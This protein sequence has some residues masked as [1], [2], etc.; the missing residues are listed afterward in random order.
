MSNDTVH[1]CCLCN[2]DFRPEALGKD[3]KC[4]TCHAQFPNVKTR[5]EMMLIN[6]PEINLGKKVTEETV[7]QIIKEELN[8]FKTV[9]MG[10]IKMAHARAAKG[11]KKDE[12]NNGDK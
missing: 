4:S 1:K 8:E 6:R 7:K 9:I 5:E 3:G 10:E 11:D 2:N 12:D